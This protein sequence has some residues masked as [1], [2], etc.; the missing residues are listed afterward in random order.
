MKIKNMNIK[1][2]KKNNNKLQFGGRRTIIDDTL[3][4]YIDICRYYRLK[5]KLYK[6]GDYVVARYVGVK[7]GDPNL[8]HSHPHIHCWADGAGFPKGSLHNIKYNKVTEY[9]LNTWGNAIFENVGLFTSEERYH[10]F[11]FIYLLAIES[12]L[13]ED[14]NWSLKKK[15]GTSG[16]CPPPKIKLYGD[17]NNNITYDVNWSNDGTNCTPNMTIDIIPHS[18]T[19]HSNTPSKTMKKSKSNNSKTRKKSEHSTSTTTVP[20]QTINIE[21]INIEPINMEPINILNFEFPLELNAVL[22]EPF[23]NFNI[24]DI[25]KYINQIID[26]I[27]S[28]KDRAGNTIK[29]LKSIREFNNTNIEFIKDELLFIQDNSNKYPLQTQKDIFY[30]LK[31]FLICLIYKFKSTKLNTLNDIIKAVNEFLDCYDRSSLPKISKLSYDEG[32]IT[33]NEFKKH[34]SRKILNVIKTYVTRKKLVK[35]KLRQ[36]KQIEDHI[37]ELNSRFD[38]PI[39]DKSIIYA[40][41][42]HMG[43]PEIELTGYQIDYLKKHI[44]DT[45]NKFSMEDAVKQINNM[46]INEMHPFFYKILS[47]ASSWNEPDLTWLNTRMKLID[48][49]LYNTAINDNDKLIIGLE[50][51]KDITG[52]NE[53][54]KFLYQLLRNNF[55]LDETRLIWLNTRMDLID[56]KLYNTAITDKA[57][58]YAGLRTMKEITGLNEDDELLYLLLRNNFQFD[59]TT[60]TW[61]NTRMDLID[62]KLYNT[63]IKDQEGLD[64]ALNFIEKNNPGLNENFELLYVIVRDNFQIDSRLLNW[65]DNKISTLNTSPKQLNQI[66]NA[67]IENNPT[68]TISRVYQQ[69]L[70]NYDWSPAQKEYISNM[71]KTDVANALAKISTKSKK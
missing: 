6:H 66:K 69:L 55:Q 8:H 41:I 45:N 54:Y 48:M 28:N 14:D 59:K 43:I 61:L 18:D 50:A 15:T 26:L 36:I 56:M 27:T 31:E 9:G 13:V 63:K 44:R 16:L 12:G 32:S 42:L 5:S 53:N 23:E 40:Y 21:P 70:N 4:I 24:N 68:M 57:G 49:K 71:K 58:L 62:M 1:N 38:N 11:L 30:T 19:L 52:L 51:I 34:S 47:D 20:N 17:I 46:E 7:D 67:I 29:N 65:L 60:L 2:T 35:D 25:I 3:D 37:V 22:N 10:W 64:L 33:L 39:R